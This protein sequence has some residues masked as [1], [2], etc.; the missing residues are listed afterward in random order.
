MCWLRGNP[1]RISGAYSVIML[2]DSIV[3]LICSCCVS[4]IMFKLFMLY[5]SDDIMLLSTQPVIAMLLFV[6]NASGYC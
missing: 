4:C 6:L 1:S 2:H 3:G 5:Y